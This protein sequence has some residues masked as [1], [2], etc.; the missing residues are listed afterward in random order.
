MLSTLLLSLL[1]QLGIPT[2]NPTL[3]VTVKG[4]ACNTGSVR[5]GVWNQATGFLSAATRIQGYTLPAKPGAVTFEITDL[6]RGTYAISVLHDKDENGKMTKSFLGWPVE[7][8][9]F[10]NNARGTFSAPAF[11]ECVFE[12]REPTELVIGIK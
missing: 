11:E 10:S 9:G 7:A 8:Y 4:T 6:P 1:L 12:L 3:R 5:L 2:E